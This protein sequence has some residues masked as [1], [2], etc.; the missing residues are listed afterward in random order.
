MRMLVRLPLTGIV[1]TVLCALQVSDQ[2]TPPIVAEVQKYLNDRTPTVKR[3]TEEFYAIASLDQAM[4]AFNDGNYGIGSVVLL[5]WKD[6]IYE[7]RDRNAMVTGYRL[8]DHAE[9]RALDRAVVLLSRLKGR[10]VPETE[11]AR[12]GSSFKPD[13][14]YGADTDYLK[15]LPDGLHVF[16]TLEPCPMCMVMMLNVAVKTSTS[17]A[18]DGELKTVDGRTVSDGAAIATDD[19][20]KCAPLVWQSIRDG[21]GLSFNLYKGDRR[22][23]DFG[24]RI[25][26][27]TREKIDEMLARQK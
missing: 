22:L 9:A 19:K 12:L 14:T 13:G 25:F 15:Q 24:L 4:K 5:K 10:S 17:L 7:Y 1:C 8:R 23:S 11:K 27:E 21:Q 6:T 16:G 20:F 3:G 2:K 26:L 18:K